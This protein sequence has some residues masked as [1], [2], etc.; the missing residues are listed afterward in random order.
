MPYGSISGS[1]IN[2]FMIRPGNCLLC[3]WVQSYFPLSLLLDSVYLGIMLRFLMHL[4]LGVFRV[5]NIVLF[6]F[7]YKYIFSRR[8]IICWRCFLLSIVRF[9]FCKNQVSVNVLQGTDFIPPINYFHFIGNH[10]G[11]IPLLSITFW[12]QGW[13]FLQKFF[14]CS[15]SF[16]YPWFLFFHMKLRIALWRSV[17]NCVRIFIGITLYL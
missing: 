6:A 3:Q 7:F 15:G 11:F 4:V 9:G 16:S 17:N 14:Y 1:V 2:G 5:I 8:D 13:W 10:K 12:G